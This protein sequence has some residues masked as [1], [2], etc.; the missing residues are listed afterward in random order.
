MNTEWHYQPKGS[1]DWIGPHSY[2]EIVMLYDTGKIVGEDLICD[3]TKSRLAYS[4]RPTF[5]DQYPIVLP[6]VAIV[7]A[8]VLLPLA[9]LGGIGYFCCKVFSNIDWVDFT[10]DWS[11]GG[12]TSNYTCKACGF[13]K[14]PVLARCPH[15]TS[16]KT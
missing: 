7:A 4:I 2:N 1:Q 3:G 9:M 15:C 16:I 11:G 8:I 10:P 6:L 12:S 14:D 13:P 5:V